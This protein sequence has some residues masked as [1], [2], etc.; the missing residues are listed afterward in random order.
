MQLGRAASAL[1]VQFTVVASPNTDDRM[2][3]R[4]FLDDQA[5]DP[6]AVSEMSA[7]FESVCQ[8]LG[9]KIVDDPATRLVAEKIIS[10]KQRGVNGVVSL[11]AMTLT[12]FTPQD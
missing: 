11:R 3:I 8:L 4:Q 5:F 12:E 7:A 10:L 2:P 9:L 1:L 6:G